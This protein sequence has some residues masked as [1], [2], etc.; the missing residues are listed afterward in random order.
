ML[1]NNLQHREENKLKSP[2]LPKR[3][4]KWLDR[5]YWDLLVYFEY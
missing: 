1:Q 3:V 4:M 5:L 2:N